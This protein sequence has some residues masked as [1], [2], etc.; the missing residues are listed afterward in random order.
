VIRCDGCASD[1]ERD[2]VATPRAEGH[3]ARYCALC[4]EAYEQWVETCAI[5]EARL[6]RILDAFIAESRTRL[7]LFFVPQ[8]LPPRERPKGLMLG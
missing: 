3:E 8:D 6:N 4:N 7:P 5:E 1:V 2:K